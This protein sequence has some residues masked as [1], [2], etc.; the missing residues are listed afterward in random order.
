MNAQEVR[1]N[2]CRTN[3]F[4][5]DLYRQCKGDKSITMSPISIMLLMGM[6]VNGASG[7]TQEEIMRALGVN[8]LSVQD[9]NSICKVLERELPLSIT[10]CVDVNSQI[11]LSDDYIKILDDVYKA[12]V[13][14]SPDIDW[15]I[16]TNS[17]RFCQNWE[18]AFEEE[19]TDV[20]KFYG[21]AGTE[22]INMMAQRDLYHYMSDKD[23][24]AVDLPYQNMRYRM[25]FVLPNP[26]VDIAKITDMLGNEMLE[27]ISSQMDLCKVDLMIP[28]FRIDTTAS[29]CNAIRALGASSIFDRTKAN[30]SNM[31]ASPLFVSD[32]RQRAYI[33]V[34]E[35]GTE[36]YAETRCYMEGS[37]PNPPQYREV[38]F[39]ANHPFI[40]MLIDERFNAVIFLGQFMGY[41]ADELLDVVPLAAEESGIIRYRVIG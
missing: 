30:F 37:A 20:K 27:H 14:E 26:G 16:L 24:S 10:N 39:I 1:E 38:A 41:E 21:N 33:D 35:Y 8:D 23:Y 9:F 3:H 18:N 7:E 34:N 11:K 12:T 40:Y 17:V 6:I 36:A 29:L 32:I 15:A 5:F 22:N 19:Y 13:N 28:K 2:I 25:R 31:S 4:M